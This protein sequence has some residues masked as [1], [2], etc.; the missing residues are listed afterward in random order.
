MIGM[1]HFTL[2][3]FTMNNMNPMTHFRC[4]AVLVIISSA[5]VSL[6]HPRFQTELG[7]P[8]ETPAI[9]QLDGGKEKD[10]ES[11]GVLRGIDLT[12]PEPDALKISPEHA[13]REILFEKSLR[14]EIIE[15]RER[16]LILNRKIRVLLDSFA[17]P[18]KADADKKIDPV[19]LKAELEELKIRRNEYRELLDDLLKDLRA[20]DKDDQ[21]KNGP[22][23]GG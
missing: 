2:H 7:G 14:I 23:P 16:L 20:P 6:A 3:T 10:L 18:E 8:P 22:K 13:L 11:L 19:R 4:L 9:I 15:V 12:I 1:H 5:V 21:E 17:F